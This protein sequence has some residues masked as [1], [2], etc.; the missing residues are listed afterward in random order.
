MKFAGPKLT[1]NIPQAN[2]SAEVVYPFAQFDDLQTFEIRQVFRQLRR[3]WTPLAL[4]TP[5]DLN[6]IDVDGVTLPTGA[7]EVFLLEESIPKD[8]GVGYCE[9]ERT[10]GNIPATRMNQQ[11]LI[12]WDRPAIHTGGVFVQTDVTGLTFQTTYQGKA[13]LQFTVSD[14]SDLAVNDSVS[15]NT[16]HYTRIQKFASSIVAKAGNTI[17]VDV[18]TWFAPQGLGPIRVRSVIKNM[19]IIRPEKAVTSAAYLQVSYQRSTS[20]ESIVLPQ[21]FEI[22]DSNDGIVNGVTATTSPTAAE[23]ADMMRDR[24]LIQVEDATIAKYKG[25]IYEIT[26][27]FVVAQ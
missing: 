24:V 26:A 22:T 6:L 16:S 17:T 5:I 12:A 23:Y 27:P 2:G 4:D 14:A 15:L 18:S 3:Y 10:Y 11:T 25:N 19:S 20:I 9:W 8:V 21:K 1:P 7:G 13:A